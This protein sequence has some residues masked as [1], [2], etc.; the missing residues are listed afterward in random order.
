MVSRASYFQKRFEKFPLCTQLGHQATGQMFHT[1][2]GS[3]P[4]P[5]TLF[6]PSPTQDA[7]VAANAVLLRPILQ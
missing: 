7:W 2:N 5:L 4:V 3:Q 1:L 6:Q